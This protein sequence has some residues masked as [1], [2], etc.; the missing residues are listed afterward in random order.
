MYTIRKS[1]SIPLAVII[2]ASTAPLLTGCF[3]NPVEGIID[4]AV[5]GAT[6]GG[7]SLGGKLPDGWP[8]EVPVID[9]EI[10]FGAGATTDGEQ[11]WV[12]TIV[13]TS[14]DPIGDAQKKLEDAGFVVDT[15]A[16]E[17]AG[18]AGLVSMMNDHYVVVVVGSADGLIYTVTP[19]T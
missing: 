12:V 5:K 19:A 14:S 6:D 9:G 10:L 7:V 11:G 13:P 3:G 16:S 8:N 2:A 4:R 1:I 15:T 17:S 18:E